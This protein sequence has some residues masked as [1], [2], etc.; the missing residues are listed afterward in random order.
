[1]QLWGQWVWE[2]LRSCISNELP[3]GGD[4]FGLYHSSGLPCWLRRLPTMWETWV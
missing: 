1:M 4:L 3:G 2:G